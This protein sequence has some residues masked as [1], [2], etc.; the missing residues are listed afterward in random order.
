MT[1][2]YEEQKLIQSVLN[3]PFRKT[4][5]IF[6]TSETFSSLIIY[7]PVEKNGFVIRPVNSNTPIEST[8]GFVL[9]ELRNTDFI[10]IA[11]RFD[12]LK[13][14]TKQ[15]VF[16]ILTCNVWY[17]ADVDFSENG[18]ASVWTIRNKS[19]NKKT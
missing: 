9:G 19:W 17:Y 16:S 13:L 12:I 2:L 11:N 7:P 3:F 18:G 5:P 4:F 6:Q 15:P 10:N 8:D 1:I 14:K